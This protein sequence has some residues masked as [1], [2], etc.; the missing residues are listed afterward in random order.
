MLSD[1]DAFYSEQQARE[2][3][4]VLSDFVNTLSDRRTYIFMSRYYLCRPIAEIADK[5]GCSQSTVNKEIAAIKQELWQ[6]LESEG[7]L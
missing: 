1:G 6:L 4:E 7:Y 2:L 3:G 5:L